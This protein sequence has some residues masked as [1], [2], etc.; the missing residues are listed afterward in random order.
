MQVA[1][2]QGKYLAKVLKDNPMI[3]RPGPNGPL[4]TG[5]FHHFHVIAYHSYA[6][7]VIQLLMK[8]SICMSFTPAISR[9]GMD[10]SMQD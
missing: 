8:Y 10:A 7:M 6:P 2:Q 5:W 1:S 3:L 4:V 9:L